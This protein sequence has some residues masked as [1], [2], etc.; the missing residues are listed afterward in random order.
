MVKI[1]PN[2]RCS[3]NC[4]T[5]NLF[6]RG[7]KADFFSVKPLSVAPKHEAASLSSTYS[8]LE[9]IRA[10]GHMG[11]IFVKARHGVIYCRADLDKWLTGNRIAPCSKGVN[12]E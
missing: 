1:T 3:R 7:F 2:T 4:V 12:H 10:N 8:T 5:Q 9:K 11:A 6:P